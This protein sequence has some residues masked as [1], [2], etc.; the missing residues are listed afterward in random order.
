MST[1]GQGMLREAIER[2]GE[3]AVAAK[4]ELSAISLESFRSGERPINDTFLLKLIDLLESIP[5]QQN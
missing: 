1:V 2:I 5:K 4:L 3:E